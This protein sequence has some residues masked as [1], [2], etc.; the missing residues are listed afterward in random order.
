MPKILIIG[1][2]VAGLSAGIYAKKAGFDAVICERSHV[3]GGNLTGWQRGEYHIDN[4]IHWL[5]GTNPATK[6]HKMWEDLGALGGV[7]I[8]RLK[9]LYTYEKNGKTLSLCRDIEKLRTDMRSISPADKKETDA[10]IAAV[11]TVMGLSGIAGARHDE[12]L[13]AAKAALRAPRLLNYAMMTTGELAARF[14]EPTL[15]G[16][17][18]SFLGEKFMALALIVV[19]ANF[20]GGN[21]DI[22]KGG[23]CAMAKRMTDR[24]IFLGGTVVLGKEAVRIERDGTRAIRAF[25]S[26][27]DAI[28]AD[29]FIIT[30]DPAVAF[31][32]LLGT[33]MPKYFSDMYKDERLM[34]FSSFQAAYSFDG[35]NVPFEG[36]IVFEVSEKFVPRLNAPHIVLRE[37]SHEKDFSPDGKNIIQAMIFCD[38]A[39]SQ[40]FI[41]MRKNQKLYA[42]TKRYI[43]TVIRQM[44]EEKFPDLCGKI[45]LIDA[46]TPA[47]YKRY[48][49]SEIGSYMSFAFSSKYV[50]RKLKNDIAK[51]RNVVLATQWLEVPG[52]LPIA[53]AAGKRAVETIIKKERKRD[54]RAASFI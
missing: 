15:R 50:P 20:C 1:G 33:P 9:T 14:H 47:T 11:K 31:G 27:G 7:E 3:T 19:F 16:F 42:K 44:I 28:S 54:I 13:T 22:P 29:Y 26:D 23:S 6:T 41:G 2:G 37:F 46:W 34:R 24:F 38:E 17:I 10:F 12:K 4:C 40:R 21:G 32:K 36:D 51:I 43:A 18:S 53:A 48:F 5:T 39:T 25:F 35:D 49:D 30:A 45:S 52:G 8:I